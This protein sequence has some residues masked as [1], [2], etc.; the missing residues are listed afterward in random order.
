MNLKNKVYFTFTFLFFLNIVDLI[1]TFIGIN[2]FGFIVEKNEN[3]VFIINEYGWVIL[4]TIKVFGVFIA[5][6]P[7]TISCYMTDNEIYLKFC[8]YCLLLLCI[9][10]IFV[11]I[12]WVLILV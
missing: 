11:I 9:I 7:L 4:S 1:V 3:I 12:N 6:L 5:G 2:R 8:L 10:F